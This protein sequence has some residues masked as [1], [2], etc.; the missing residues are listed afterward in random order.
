M[1]FVNP[2]VETKVKLCPSCYKEQP[3][4]EFEKTER[5]RVRVCKLCRTCRNRQAR[6]KYKK[7]GGRPD[8]VDNLL[9]LRDVTISVKLLMTCMSLYT[10]YGVQLQIKRPLTMDSELE[11]LVRELL[12]QRKP[13]RDAT[14]I[15]LAKIKENNLVVNF[16]D[17]SEKYIRSKSLDYEKLLKS[18]G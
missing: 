13:K 10:N 14:Y 3:I 11:S 18:L 16:Y 7:D 17:S 9:Q 5:G 15:K 8:R 1:E 4:S 12:V 2:N 6:E